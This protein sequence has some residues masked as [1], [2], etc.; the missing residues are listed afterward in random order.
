M[1][2]EKK[3]LRLS[4]PLFFESL[5]FSVIGSVDTMMLSNYSDT[6][7]GAVGVAN[8]VLFLVLIAGNIIAQGAGIL[9]TQIV[10]AKR[11]QEDMQTLTLTAFL[12]NTVTGLVLS[13]LLVLFKGS[14][15]S[16]MNLQGEMLNFAS[17]YFTIIS[18]FLFLH[19]MTMTFSVYLRSHG[20]TK[21]T[22]KVSLVM[23][24][25]NVVFNY[26][27]IYGHLGFDALG[28]RGAAYA[29]VLSRVVGFLVL[30]YLV[31]R[32]AFYKKKV[33]FSL[34]SILRVLPKIL[35]LGAP[36]AGEQI[37]YNLAKFVMMIF[38]TRLGD[39]AIT[40]YS[41]SNTL[42]SF[43]YIFSFSLGQGA[44]ILIGW[45][46]GAG[47]SQ[48]AQK[49]GHHAAKLSFFISMSLCTLLI[50]L[51]IPLLG[52]LTNDAEIILIAGQVLLFNFL[53]EAGRS[54]NLIY[55]NALRATGEV[56][57]PFKVAV[58]SMWGIGVLFAYI[59]SGPL[60]LGLTGV[61]IAL[62]LDEI[63]RALLLKKRWQKELSPILLNPIEKQV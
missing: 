43:V 1:N 6:A 9:M 49:L 52:F 54:Q 47:N 32:S 8:Q 26:L 42:V 3:L 33:S 37:S 58:L 57:Y 7:V 51:R 11:S 53:V 44:S 18:S 48:R 13:L 46:M 38:I 63:T 45:H 41:Y 59:L 27:L 62:G 28:V 22:L 2:D 10:G 39:A 19:L 35:K 56:H 21:T 23:N 16:V 14:I 15:L 50:L 12:V 29:T 60:H 4:V 5:L 31:Y 36:A 17:D 20:K 24:L 61:W 40:A 34:A 25:I 55:V 30:G